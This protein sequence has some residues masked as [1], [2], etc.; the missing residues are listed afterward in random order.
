MKLLAAKNILITGRPGSGKSTLINRLITFCHQENQPLGGISTPEIRVSGKR[1]GFWII[2][3]ISGEKGRMAT[4]G[5]NVPPFVGRY[6]VDLE[7]IDRIGVR[8]IQQA[9]K[10]DISV[11][12]ID[13]IGKMELLS[14]KF[15]EIIEQALATQRV[16][17]TIGRFKHPFI[18]KIQ[19]RDDTE[20]L[21]IENNFSTLLKDLQEI[22][23]KSFV[24]TELG[25]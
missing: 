14:S 11:I 6:S 17:G 1:E 21:A 19:S 3:L 23:K 15:C 8:A 7:V 9:I 12:F 20:V 16:I 2:N 24:K 25:S 10:N 22:L 13:E 18:S 5:A 4:R